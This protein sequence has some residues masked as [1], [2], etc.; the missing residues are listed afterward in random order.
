MT[1]DYKIL[2]MRSILRLE[3]VTDPFTW[4][5]EEVVFAFAA[6]IKQDNVPYETWC[7]RM[8][9]ESTKRTPEEENEAALNAL[10][11]TAP[12]HVTITEAEK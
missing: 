3:V 5:D 8:G 7:L 9:L 4:P 1:A 2:W 6:R 10:R 12:Q 11:A